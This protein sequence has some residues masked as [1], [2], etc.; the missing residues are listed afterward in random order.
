MTKKRTATSV[1]DE[2]MDWLKSGCG[3]LAKDEIAISVEVGENGPL[4]RGAIKALL[5][6]GLIVETHGGLAVKLVPA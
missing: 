1:G 3:A 4:L 6:R 5:D 2:I